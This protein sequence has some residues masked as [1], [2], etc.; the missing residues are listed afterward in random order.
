LLK[1]K[2]FTLWEKVISRPEEEKYQMVLLEKED[3]MYRKLPESD[4]I[5]HFGSG[6]GAPRQG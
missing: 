6:E 2:Y 3:H 1:P 4:C 5:Q